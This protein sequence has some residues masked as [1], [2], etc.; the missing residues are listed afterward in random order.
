MLTSDR[1]AGICG[2]ASIDALRDLGHPPLAAGAARSPG[3]TLVGLPD[4]LAAGPEPVPLDGRA[5]R[6]RARHLRWRGARRPGGH[7][8][9]QRRRQSHR[10]GDARVALPAGRDDVA[11]ERADVVRDRAEGVACRHRPCRRHLGRQRPG[12]TPGGRRG[13]DTGRIPSRRAVHRSTRIRSGS[14]CPAEGAVQ[15]W[16]WRRRSSRHPACS[17]RTARGSGGW[18]WRRRRPRRL[19]RRLVS[20]CRP[21]N[22]LRRTGRRRSVCRPGIGLDEAPLVQPD[23]PLHEPGVGRQPDEHEHCRQGG[24]RAARRS[25]CRASRRRS[26]GGRRLAARRSRRWGRRRL[27]G[28]SAI[29]STTIFDAVSS[30]SRVA[31]VT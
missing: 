24:A 28:C 5:A 8:P 18:R 12:G 15:T 1:R 17:R 25:R 2:S 23:E 11:R 30:G 26:R 20:C 6:G 29:F 21:C 4:A 22:R 3:A 14:P 13:H 16:S 31:I 10:M 9:P 19:P 27:S 7:R